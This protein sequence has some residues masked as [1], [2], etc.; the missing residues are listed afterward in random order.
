M[1]ILSVEINCMRGIKHL[2][3]DFRGKNA[4]IY[5][6]NGTGKSGV[7]DALDFLIKGDITRLSGL[8]SKNLTLNKHGLYVTENIDQSWIKAIVRLPNYQE[9]IEIKRCLNNPGILLCDPKYKVDFDRINKLANLQVHYLSRREILQFINATDQER[10]KSI[11]KLLNLSSLEKNRISLQKAKKTID[12]EVKLI[13]AQEAEYIRKISE[14]LGVEQKYWLDEINEIRLQLGMKP[15][16]DLDE[17]T[18]TSDLSLTKS[19]ITNTE[20]SFL[21]Q[22]IEDIY[23]TFYDGAHC[24]D[25]QIMTAKLV[26]EKV[27]LSKEYEEQISSIRLYE[28]G[29]KLLKDDI[30]PLCGQEIDNREKLLKTLKDK[31]NTLKETKNIFIDYQNTIKLL[32]QTLATIKNQ[33]SLIDFAKLSNYVNAKCLQDISSAVDDLYANIENDRFSPDLAQCFLEHKYAETIKSLYIDELCKISARLALNQKEA[34]Y[35]KLIDV[36][37]AYCLLVQ[38]Q[39]NKN[40]LT[41]QAHRASVLFE[42]YVA[43]QTHVLNGMYDSIQERFTQFYK[44]IHESDES[45]FSSAFNRKAASLEL[46]VKFKDDKMY[47]PN[48]VHSEG[49]QDSMGIC[50]FFALSEKISDSQLNLVLLDDVVMSIDIDHRKNFCKLLKEQFPQKQFIIT[51]HDYIWRKELEAQGIVAKQNI[52]H[53]KSWDIKHGPYVEIGT[54]VWEAINSHLGKGEKNEAIGLM[55]Y[56]MEEFFSDIC[57]KYRLK[58]PYSTSGR[59]SLEDVLTPVI[60]IYSTAIKKAKESAVSFNKPVDKIEAYEKV[61]KTA[62]SNLQAERWAINPSTHFTTWAQSLSIDELKLTCSAVKAFCE[63]FECPNCKSFITINSDINLAPLNIC[64]DCG[65]YSFSCIKKKS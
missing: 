41:N 11:E 29:Q 12:D 28:E 50:L 25:A 52:I 42:A 59:W 6:D 62:L 21:I 14:K 16:V 46:Q 5:G 64:C 19:T 27:L 26:L 33:F 15:I 48:A 30:C 22:K 4:V 44:I 53:F 9:E 31:I 40:T 65:D 1:I 47:P 35:K 54:N 60:S 34:N 49:H 58:V 45:A 51:T 20:V 38:T 37:A 57:A 8:G 43:S 10:A 18:I 32:Q 56:Y 55:R 63:T 3:L 24:L 36:G 7:I 2:I 61:Y 39:R 17:Y 13:H 23:R